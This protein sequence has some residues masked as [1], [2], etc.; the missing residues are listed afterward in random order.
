MVQVVDR[1]TYLVLV[2]G[3]SVDVPLQDGAGGYLEGELFRIR[4]G[5]ASGDGQ[6]VCVECPP[7][8]APPVRL[9]SYR[10]IPNCETP[11]VLH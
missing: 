1:N 9:P 5:G 10:A 6:L 8:G 2:L 7:Q 3:S 11:N 4:P